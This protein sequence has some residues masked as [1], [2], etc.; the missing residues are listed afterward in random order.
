[1]LVQIGRSDQEAAGRDLLDE[2][3][4]TVN[5]AAQ[6][7]VLA[8]LVARTGERVELVEKQNAGLTAGKFEGLADVARRLAQVGRDQAVE[9]YMEEGQA[10]LGCEDLS[11]KRL[12]SSGRAAKEQF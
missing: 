6:L 8:G 7:I 3:Q 10:K 11:A 9:T 2:N 5:D 1:M 12:A 4:E